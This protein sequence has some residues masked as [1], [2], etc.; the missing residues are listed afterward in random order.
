MA[1]AR[2]RDRYVPQSTW[3]TLRCSTIQVVTTITLLALSASL[4]TVQL[5][6]VDDVMLIALTTAGVIVLGLALVRLFGFLEANG[7]PLLESEPVS[8]T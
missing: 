8:I 5:G 3:F 2:T 1:C 4:L 7:I 6:A